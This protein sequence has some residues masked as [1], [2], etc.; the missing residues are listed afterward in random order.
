MRKL[1]PEDFARRAL[2][3]L[4]RDLPPEVKR[5]LP[6]DYV[7]R[8]LPLVQERVKLLKEV[9]PLTYYFFVD[10]L[11]YETDL[12]IGKEMTAESTIHALE[13]SRDRLSRQGAFDAPTLEG[14][15]RPLAVELGLK[16]GQLF[17]ALRT[18]V[19]GETATPP[20]FDMMAVLGRERCLRRIEEAINKLK[21]IA[22]QE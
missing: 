19:S 8:V 12:L 10:A 4:E 21:Q 6:V 14:I 1:P 7:K 18:A 13:V 2:V 22:T 3:F 11:E 20:L 9:T 15:L 5:P 16:T 17:G